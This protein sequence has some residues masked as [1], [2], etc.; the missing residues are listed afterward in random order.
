MAAEQEARIL[1]AYT[2]PG[3][4]TAFSAPARVA[5]HFGISKTR[6]KEI[7]EGNEGYTLHREYKQ[8]A[9][10]N[11]YYVHKRREQVQA[12]LIDVS[13]IAR[14]ND[15]VRFLLLLIDIFT[16]RVWVVPLRTK[17]AA[18]MKRAMSVWLN[19]LRTKPDQLATDRGLE[20]TNRGVQGLLRAHN[21]MWISAQGTMKAAVA[22][23]ANKTVQILIYKYLTENESVR[24]IDV[25]PALIGSYNSRG[26]RTLEGMTPREADRPANEGRVQGIFH[27]RYREVARHRRAD[28]PLKVGNLVRVKT[29]AKKSISSSS[30][31]YAEQ[32][33]GEYFRIVRINRTLPIAMY[34]LRSLDTDE[35]IEGGFYANELQRQ[36]GELWK[37]E[38]V[39]RRRVRRGVPQVLVKWKYF[40]PRHNE[41]I[42]EADVRR[43]YGDN[44]VDG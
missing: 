3:H 9:V 8:P 37:I 44:V 27:E 15:G 28:L 38:A 23:R 34:Y 12:D 1:R 7:L 25:L 19:S 29:D 6:A 41:W 4:P 42:P 16:K 33:H 11:P 20:F 30:R 18:E 17:A 13:K 35:Y 43:V 24:Y 10:Y 32:F 40:G 5:S 21:V 26:H 31:A 36:R 14:A 2:T 22:E 39:L